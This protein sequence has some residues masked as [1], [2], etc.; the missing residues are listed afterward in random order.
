VSVGGKRKVGRKKEKEGGET[1]GVIARGGGWG[2]WRVGR[3]RLW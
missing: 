1:E 2:M 3:R